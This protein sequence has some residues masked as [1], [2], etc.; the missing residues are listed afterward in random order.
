MRVEVIESLQ[1]FATP[2]RVD[3]VAG[4]G[5]TDIRVSVSRVVGDAVTVDIAAT[6][7]LTCGDLSEANE[8]R[9]GSSRGE[10]ERGC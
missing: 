7:G 6:D 9:G 4:V 3:L 2:G 10:R 8:F 5:S 1:I